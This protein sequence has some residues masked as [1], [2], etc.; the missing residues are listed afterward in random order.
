LAFAEKHRRAVKVDSVAE[1][2]KPNFTISISMTPQEKRLELAFGIR[3]LKPRTEVY[4]QRDC[5]EAAGLPVPVGAKR[6]V[7][8]RAEELDRLIAEAN[9]ADQR[10]ADEAAAA[11][12]AANGAMDPIYPA[13]PDFLAD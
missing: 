9:Q 4:V 11:A 8:L 6:M 7:A 3:D 10:A 1:T 12:A 13:D 2:L 5:L